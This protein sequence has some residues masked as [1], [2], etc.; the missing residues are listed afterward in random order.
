MRY[1]ISKGSKSFGAQEVFSNVTFEVKDQ[2]KIAIVGRNGCGKTT[3]LRVIA[4]EERLDQGEIHKDKNITIGYLSQT[5]FFDETHSVEAEFEMI[6]EELHRLESELASLS[7]KMKTDTDPTLVELYG[8]YQ[9][10]H[11]RLG[12]YTYKNEIHTIFT[13]FGFQLEDLSKSL[14]AFSGGQKTR[15]A[16]VK[17]L[18]T[19]PDILLL[20]EPTNHLDLDTIKW[21]ESYVKR[22]PKAV[23]MVSHDRIF[24]DE[25]CDVIYE[26]EN[27]RMM[28][29]VG[30]YS[31]YVTLKKQLMEKN[32]SAFR[33]QQEEIE[34]LEMLID[35]FRYK[36]SK[37]KF[38]Q[39]KIKY[40]DRLERVE[41]M[42][43]DSKSFKAN[44]HSRI[45][46]G[47]QVLVMKDLEIGYDHTLCKLDLEIV[48]GQRI[49]IIGPNGQGKS[50][51]M[52]TLMKQIQP[53]KGSFMYGH[54]IETGYFDQELAQFPS[55]QTVLETVWDTY[56]DLD[57]TAI[58]TALGTFLFKQDDVFK[59]VGVLSGGEK[60]RLLFVNLML[61]QPNLLLLDEPT[62]HLDIVGKEALEDALLNYDGT[63]LF[64]SHDRYFINKIANGILKIDQGT[65]TYYPLTLDALQ[66][67]KKE[68]QV[69]KVVK[70]RNRSI[71]Y[72]KEISKLERKITSLE[73]RLEARRLLRFEPEY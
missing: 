26:L 3:L 34:R 49:A 40:L 12:G 56:P 46:G 28:K 25:V 66:E 42:Q 9:D 31:N 13:K 8:K 45:K 33:N 67:E 58:R 32:R 71:N 11:E 43:T 57:R 20:D 27:H 16:F 5:S 4:S 41:L 65:A 36:K 17:L 63:M 38:A 60:V 10:Q 50:T 62:N 18:L 72:S 30:N 59:E 54:Q 15:I 2:E 19:K 24:L 39:S 68:T 14:Q 37:A 73:E 61:Q 6:F 21:L 1:Q 29:F 69:V 70:E 55:H 44:F 64:V 22:Y 23:V 53:L 35:K 47:K 51:L 52:K 7:E 48:R